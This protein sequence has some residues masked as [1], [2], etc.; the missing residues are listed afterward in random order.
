[1]SLL[2][3]IYFDLDG[4]V[5]DLYNQPNWL[6]RITVTFDATAY[7]NDNAHLVDIVALNEQLVKMVE[8]G[9]GVGVVTW[10]ALDSTTNYDKAVR[11]VKREWVAKFLPMAQEVHVVRYGTPKHNVIKDKNNAI[12]VDDNAEVRQAWTR[13]ITID[14]TQDII[15]AL[16]EIEH[17]FA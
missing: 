2:P 15:Q 17:L 4:T 12:L 11:K 10:L 3:T 6:E 14:A 7:A 9:F 1:M 5:Y 13:G 16:K 8:M